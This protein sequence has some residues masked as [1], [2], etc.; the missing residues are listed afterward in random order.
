VRSGNGVPGLLPGASIADTTNCSDAL[1]PRN[2]WGTGMTQRV[3]ESEIRDDA[4]VVALGVQEAWGSCGNVRNIASLLGWT[5]SPERGGLGLITR[6]G[7]VGAYEWHQIEFR[8]AGA[9][10]DRWIVGANV[11]TAPDC[12]ETMYIWNTHLAATTDDQWVAHV[13][14]LLEWLRRRPTPHLFVGDLNIWEN[15]RWSPQ[16]NCGL[17]TPAMSAA[18]ASI[19]LA[20]YVDAWAATQPTPG[21]TATLSRPRCGP[22]GDG[23]AYKRVDYIWLKGVEAVSS[24]RFGVVPG[25]TDAPSDHYGVKAR[26]AV[27]RP[28]AP[29]PVAP[30]PVAPFPDF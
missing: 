7:V 18:L 29:D 3:L 16:T 6:Y 22:D 17:A 24:T 4:D 15:D 1:R 10:E 2:A 14:K 26:L 5:A 27:A 21:W 9:P 25:G 30:D 19:R 28:P 20:G 23:G 11:C 13:G 8:S 12:V